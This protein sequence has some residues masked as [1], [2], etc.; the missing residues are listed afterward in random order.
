MLRSNSSGVPLAHLDIVCISISSPTDTT[1]SGWY[2]LIN[3]DKAFT[4]PTSW[5]GTWR[6]LMQTIVFIW[7]TYL[8]VS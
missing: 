5:Y 4:A 2:D 8:A 6:S 7:A 3:F 1:V